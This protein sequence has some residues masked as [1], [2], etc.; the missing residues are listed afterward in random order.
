MKELVNCPRISSAPA[1][2]LGKALAAGCP[3]C[4]ITIVRFAEEPQWFL[5]AVNGYQYRKPADFRELFM[6]P[7]RRNA[8]VCGVTPMVLNRRLSIQQ[9]VFLCPADVR[10]SLVQNLKEMELGKG[11]AFKF[12]LPVLSPDK[13]ADVFRQLHQMNVTARSLFPGLGGYCQTM[14]HRLKFL[15]GLRI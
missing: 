7:N 12:T 4:T 13:M 5:R 6:K 8:F 14:K 9:G 11:I 2:R 1:I 3:S 10:K 15:Y